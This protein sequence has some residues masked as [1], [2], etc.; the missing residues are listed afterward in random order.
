MRLHPVL[1]LSCG[2]LALP[3]AAA[4]A[5]APATPSG[6]ESHPRGF[7]LPV[8]D[9]ARQQALETGPAWR[10]FRD[11][12]GDWRGFWNEATPSPHRAV[13]P[14][15]A[16]GLRSPDPAGV[17]RAVR[18]F[19]AGHADLFGAPALELVSLRLV[20]GTWY[21]R[22]RQT[23]RGVPVLFEDWEFRVGGNGRLM[24]F[25]ADAHRIPAT[26]ITVPH[27]TPAQARAAV[28]AGSAAPLEFDPGSG[29]PLYLLPVETAGGTDYRLVY[30][31]RTI[32]TAPPARIVTLVDAISGEIAWR[33]DMTRHAIGGNV[34][35]QVHLTLPGDPL[36]S[37]P[38]EFEIVHVGNQTSDTTDAA[39]NYSANVTG[40]N[41]VTSQL[42][43]PFCAVN[44]ASGQDASF[45]Q[46]AVN[47]ATVN[48][49]WSGANSLD[50]ERDGYYHVNQMHAYVRTLDPGLTFLDYAMPCNVE[51]GGDV[52]NAFWD[53]AGVNFY[54]AGGGCPSMATLPDVIYHEYGHGVN[55]QL[56]K[57]S[58]AP[59]GMLNGA[60]HEGMADVVAAFVQDDPVVGQGFF[61]AG[62][63]LRV[64]DNTARWPADRSGDPHTTGLILAGA[65]WD[66]R[67]SLGLPL[68]TTLSH[69]AKYGH[70]DDPDDGV[71][72]SEY[73]LE[74]L[75]V[76]DDDADLANGTPHFAAI[77]AAFN[78]HGIGS[79]YFLGITHQPLVDSP[80][81]GPFTVT[82]TLSYTPNPAHPFGAL[83][84]ASA[85]LH[86]SINGAAFT[87]RPMTLAGPPDQY[88]APIPAVS[89]AIVRYYLSVS[90][91]QG[92]SRTDPDGAPEFRTHVFI[93]GPYTTALSADLET[94]PGW[95]VGGAGDGA[96][97]GVWLRAEPVGTAI[98]GVEVQPQLDHTPD[99]GTLCFVTGNAAPSDA[100]GTN[101]VDGGRTTLTT[102]VFS[103]LGLVQPAIEYYR[104][105]S[106]NA[107][108]D[109]GTDR[110]RVEISN[111]GGTGWTPIEDTF[112]TDNRWRRVV[113]M[114]SDF[115][116][117][118]AAMRL[119]FIAEDVGPASLIE[120]AVDDLRLLSLPV[121]TAVE[122]V[123][124]AL[125]LSA[126]VPNP[127]QG[128]QRL[129]FGLPRR[130]AVSL[131]V[132]DLQGRLIRTLVDGVLESGRFERHWDG[133]DA[134]GKPVGSGLYFARL[135]VDGQE[136]VTMLVRLR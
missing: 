33:H 114:I 64:L 119:R 61:G 121:T 92:G 75:V 112:G 9:A 11:R 47:P 78:A 2:L 117:P 99:P 118:T 13:G 55:D 21:A 62:T 97:T 116:P 29:E 74:T 82:A 10:Q 30:E 120:A 63:V 60:L 133:R 134:D 136:R 101:D 52:C 42:A 89:G 16:L 107:G 3:A 69:Y 38:F 83:D 129:A 23:L 56:Y 72:M 15:I 66:L 80:G 108:A 20:R 103:A 109:P 98:G 28:G 76:D 31:V 128:E 59:I 106:N 36:T 49:V 46:N 39:G 37:R 44:R 51:V 40:S 70:P 6:V 105:Y 87:A 18:T 111:D 14:S 8:H 135:R 122:A 58:G 86:Y 41:K 124:A 93:A 110:W 32:Q 50:S 91:V 19:V 132:H 34:S 104:W 100:P 125:F 65:F 25:G 27:L 123:D 43:G 35:G 102:P 1:L 126:P 22:Y 68:A 48:I 67:E 24:M 130:A 4:A 53:G 71:A 94:D 12:H 77:N 26:T 90:D 88:T 79:A 73:F 54:A 95:T 131:R 7:R 113:F 127:S 85:T 84:P 5:R 45:S 96:T 17:D 81:P 57:Q 115:L